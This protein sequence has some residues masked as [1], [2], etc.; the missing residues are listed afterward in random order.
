[1]SWFRKERNDPGRVTGYVQPL[2]YFPLFTAQAFGDRCTVQAV[3]CR[4]HHQKG[5]TS[6]LG[7]G[8]VQGQGLLVLTGG[9]SSAYHSGL[10]LTAIGNT[11]MLVVDEPLVE[12]CVNAAEADLGYAANFQPGG[13][14]H[15]AVKVLGMERYIALLAEPVPPNIVAIDDQD[16][17]KHRQE[18]EKLMRKRPFRTL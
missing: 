13:Y 15:W 18:F 9:L 1:M 7:V 3:V 14:S 8:N 10:L 2:H 17:Q 4:L 16:R 6:C 12:Q 5:P 11:L